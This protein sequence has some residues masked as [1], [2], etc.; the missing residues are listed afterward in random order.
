MRTLVVT[1][2]L[3]PRSGG[4]ETFVHELLIRQD[5]STFVVLGPANPHAASYDTTVPFT[6]VRHRTAVLPSR[7]MVRVIVALARQFGCDQVVMPSAMP[8]GLMVP[9][10]R[11]AGMR[12]R[13]VMTHGN[14]AGWLRVPGM[15]ALFGRIGKADAVSYLGAYTRSRIEPALR[16]GAMVR[17]LAP[18]VDVT[19]FHPSVDGSALREQWGLTD[20]PVV[21]CISRLVPRKGQDRLIQAWPAVRQR[22]PGARLLIVGDGPHRKDLE[23]LAAKHQVTDA[24]VFTGRVEHHDLPAYYAACDVFAMPC[25]TR[26]AGIDVEGLGIVFLEASAVGRPVIAGDSGG[27]PDAVD[28]GV[29]GVV[30]PDRLDVLVDALCDLL[31]DPAKREQM[32]RAGRAWVEQHW[33]WDVPARRYAALVEGRDPDASM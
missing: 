6:V 4:I 27:A 32:G 23:R 2:D 22:I 31:A 26:R 15:A 17:R 29:T 1:N 8:V 28:D 18:A 9:A 19:R 3:P 12:V 16:G 11:R 24:V 7:S 33:T 21:A 10:L 20:A 5:P 25:R 30:V 14:E 13:L